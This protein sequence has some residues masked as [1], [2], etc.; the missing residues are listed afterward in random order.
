MRYLGF[1]LFFFFFPR[2]CSIWKPGI[3][4]KPPLRTMPPLWQCD[5]LNLL[6]HSGNYW[7][8]LLMK[9][10]CINYFDF[11]NAPT[12]ALSNSPI[13]VL[14]SFS[15]II[16]FIFIPSFCLIQVSFVH[17]LISSSISS[18][19][20]HEIFSPFVSYVFN[21]IHFSLCTIFSLPS[22]S[23]FLHS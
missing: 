13:T 11:S 15:L 5:I 21:A 10:R 20:W 9:I 17:F 1:Y 14:F 16:S 6:H 19:L 7:G 8:F 23:Y 12:F 22:P 4:S 3:E 18:G 2:T